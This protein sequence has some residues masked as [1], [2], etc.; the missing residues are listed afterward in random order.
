MRY[1]GAETHGPLTLHH[2][3]VELNG[4][5]ADLWDYRFPNPVV[6]GSS[7]ITLA[8]TWRSAAPAVRPSYGRRGSPASPS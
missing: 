6:A 2:S 7:G 8:A 1:L 5:V 3:R 4:M